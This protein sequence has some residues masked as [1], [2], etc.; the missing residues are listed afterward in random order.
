MLKKNVISNNEG[1]YYA[2]RSEFDDND[3]KYKKT[4][5]TTIQRQNHQMSLII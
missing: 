3:D 4:T 1:I 5:T 2:P